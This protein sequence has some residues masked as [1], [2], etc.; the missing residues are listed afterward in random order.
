MK[1]KELERLNLEISIMKRLVHPHIAK[2]FEALENPRKMYLVMEYVEKSLSSYV[3]EK[4]GLGEP[5]AKTLF[6]Q[7]LSAVEFCHSI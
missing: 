4:G 5:E 7:I 3:R 1:T 2:F 6:V